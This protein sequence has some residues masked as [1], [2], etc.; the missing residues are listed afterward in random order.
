[1]LWKFTFIKIIVFRSYSGTS[2]I[3]KNDKIKIKKLL[4]KYENVEQPE[5]QT[6]E[7]FEFRKQGL[8]ASDIWKALIHS[9]PKII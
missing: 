8:S 1:M 3:Q 5:Q 9:L 2:I 6:K 4:K 7:W